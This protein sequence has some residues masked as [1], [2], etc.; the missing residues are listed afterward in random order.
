MFITGILHIALKYT[1]PGIPALRMIDN[2]YDSS[3]GVSLVNIPVKMIAMFII[4]MINYR[5]SY[6]GKGSGI[7]GIL[8][9]FVGAILSVLGKELLILGPVSQNVAPEPVPIE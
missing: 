8:A 1:T 6:C 7:I 4:S 5:S 9:S 2:S 3:F